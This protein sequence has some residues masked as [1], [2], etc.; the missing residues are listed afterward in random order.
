MVRVRDAPSAWTLGGASA[1][2]PY[3]A[4]MSEYARCPYCGSR[5]VSPTDKF[6]NTQIEPEECIHDFECGTC[7]GLFSIIYSPIAVRKW[8]SAAEQEAEA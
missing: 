2:L 7:E 4:M 8:A 6:D 3:E 5:D 1:D